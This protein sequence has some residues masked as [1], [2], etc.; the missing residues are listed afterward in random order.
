MFT[1]PTFR[2]A[3]KL[4]KKVEQFIMKTDIINGHKV[5]QFDYL[6][7]KPSDFTVTSYA[8]ELRG[9]AYVHKWFGLIKEPFPMLHKF[10]NLNECDGYMKSDLKGYVAMSVQSKEDGSVIS[11]I[12]IGDEWIAKSHYSFESYQAKKSQELLTPMLKEFL[13]HTYSRGMYPVF[14]LVGKDNP[15]VV[16][17]DDMELRLLQIRDKVGFYYHQQSRVE[18]L[19]QNSFGIKVAEYHNISKFKNLEELLDHYVHL[20]EVTEDQEGWIINVYNPVTEDQKLIKLKTHWYMMLH[21]LLTGSSLFANNIIEHVL[22]GDLDDIVSQMQLEED[23]HRKKFIDD[24][25]MKTTNF[26]NENYKRIIDILETDGD[27]DKK[28][29]AM[30][31]KSDKLFHIIVKTKNGHDIETLLKDHIMFKTRRKEMADA[32]LETGEL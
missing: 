16:R 12:K 8:K 18:Y 27:M 10:H 15:I 32:F 13:D 25:L 2:Q 26:Y 23:D 31:H 28:E 4:V 11:F 29:F 6:L 20:S 1:I 22:K 3:K 17:Y 24:V 14:E 7:A 21:G 30:K 9:I 5:S 19:A